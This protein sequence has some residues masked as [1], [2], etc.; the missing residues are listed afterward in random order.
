MAA[1]TAR[2]SRDLQ[3][4]VRQLLS[5]VTAAVSGSQSKVLSL[6]DVIANLETNDE[7]FHRLIKVE[8]DHL[9]CNIILL[10]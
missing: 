3:R 8:G 9:K 4:S 6:E 2:E 7:N 1:E 5:G 10:F